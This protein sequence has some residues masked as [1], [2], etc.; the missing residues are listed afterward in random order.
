MSAGTAEQGTAPDGLLFHWLR[1]RQ[2]AN[3]GRALAGSAFFRPLTISLVS[4]LVWSFV[5]GVSYAGFDFVHREVKL[6]MTG[7]II[8][9]VIN[10][11]FLTLGVLLIFSSGLI[12][13]G[14]LFASPETVF[15]LSKPIRDDRVFAYKFQGAVAF[16]S[17]AFLLLGMPVLL[18]YGL[19]GEAPWHFYFFLPFFFLG[20][21]LLPGSLGALLCLAVVNLVPQRRQ[22]VLILAVVLL[23]V[24]L[25]LWG[26]QLYQATGRAVD[27][28]GKEAMTRLLDQFAFASGSLVPSQWV[29]KG[30]QAAARNKPGAAAEYLALVWSN[31]LMLYLVAAWASTWLYRR[32]FNRLS[33]GGTLRRRVGGAWLDALLERAL[34]FLPMQ[35]RLL[36]GKDFRTFRRDPQQWG[37]VLVFTTLLLLYITNI[38]RLFVYDIGWGYQNTISLLNL[39]AVCLLLCTYTGR[40][41]YPLLSLEGRK[42]WI[43]GLLPLRRERLLWGKFAFATTG[44]LILSLP[45]V[46]LSDVMLEMPWPALVL[47]ALIALVLASGLS[48]LAVGLG[49]ALPNF[50]ETDPSKIAVGFGGTLNLVAGLGLL[51]LTL[52]FMA[53]PW[54]LQMARA[55]GPQGQPLSWLLVGLGVVMGLAL[56][57]VAITLP[58]RVGIQRLREMEF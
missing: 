18:A 48:G 40:F 24:L 34:F 46:L 29:A 17:W 45:L 52:V 33:T 7:E 10:M 39:C 11:M 36:I 12:L 2:L 5:F 1:W 50:R 27:G 38:R 58:L 21:T 56:G 54:H 9:I 23:L 37:Q 47:H 22:Q 44:S 16:S 32:G 51:M 14:S 4:L 41:V 8:S 15:L 6:P 30:L 42:F 53:L 55:Q 13:F 19:V 28:G 43:L 25:G 31:G 3:S 35:L 49:A 26:Y 57:L 20:F